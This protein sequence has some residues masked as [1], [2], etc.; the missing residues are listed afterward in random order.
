MTWM[1]SKVRVLRVVA[2]ANMDEPHAM[3]VGVR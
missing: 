3:L 2:E 1:I